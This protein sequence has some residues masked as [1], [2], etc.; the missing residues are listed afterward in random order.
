MRHLPT[1]PRMRL[2]DWVLSALGVTVALGLAGFAGQQS[3]APL[4]AQIDRSHDSDADGIPNGQEIVLGT[5]P[6]IADSD[7][8]G[9]LDGEELALQTSPKDSNSIPRVQDTSVGMTAR[10]ENGF[11]KLFVAVYT[12]E[13]SHQENNIR[14]AALMGDELVNLDFDRIVGTST[15]ST[16]VVPGGRLIGFDIPIAPELIVRHGSVTFFVVIGEPGSTDYLASACVD[17][18]TDQGILMMR[19]DARGPGTSGSSVNN[20]SQGNGGSLFQPIPQSGQNAVPITWTPNKI[21]FQR[22]EVTG[23]VG[24]L[25]SVQIVEADCID[26]WESY[27]ASDCE[28]TVGTTFRRVDPGALIGN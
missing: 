18:T 28:L 11:L 21:C 16:V 7:F 12:Q 10:G 17:I 27:C 5:M 1:A 26:G 23:V 6:G 4:L 20:L 2:P 25:V 14:F 9:Y 13:Q 22:Q 8:D 24:A 15:V 19:R 3:K